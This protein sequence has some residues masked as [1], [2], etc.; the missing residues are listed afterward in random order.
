[1][2]SCSCGLIPCL[3]A[4]P[5]LSR[6][7]RVV[8]PSLQEE[9][10][11]RVFFG[12]VLVKDKSKVNF[13]LL[14]EPLDRLAMAA[15]CKGLAYLQRF[16]RA[17]PRVRVRLSR[18]IDPNKV[19][20]WRALEDVSLE[21]LCTLKYADLEAVVKSLNTI[22]RLSLRGKS[23]GKR[24]VKD[25]LKKVEL[26]ELC[27]VDVDTSSLPT[28]ELAQLKRLHVT[29][30]ATTTKKVTKKKKQQQKDLLLLEE[31]KQKTSSSSGDLLG[32]LL[33]TKKSFGSR[34]PDPP[35][36]RRLRRLRS[37]RSPA[38]LDLP[39]PPRD[40]D[41]GADDVVETPRDP[42]GERPE[43][44]RDHRLFPG[45]EPEAVSRPGDRRAARPANGGRHE[46]LRRPRRDDGDAPLSS[47]PR[48]LRPR[49]GFS[50]L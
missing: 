33:L 34:G 15:T 16:Q 13:L 8:R 25:V 14:L 30:P 6:Q 2:S 35:R 26:T 22:K 29:L 31:E 41:R 19:A 46:L 21:C 47:R 40:D 50:G 38:E 1:M 39:R 27:L 32:Q 36:R 17:W 10:K 45:S 5:S 49:G 9:G 3:C 4:G 23:F 42:Q 12:E 43:Q 7:A 24:F 37:S 20:F 48:P 18:A 44:Q 28:E 11:T